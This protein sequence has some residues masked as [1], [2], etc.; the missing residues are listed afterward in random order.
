M[1]RFLAT[2]CLLFITAAC[3]Y[4]Q[5]VLRGTVR[6]ELTG[7]PM[8]GVT[9]FE[10]GTSNGTITDNEGQYELR[11][12]DAQ[13]T[14]V[15][16]FVGY[17]TVEQAGGGDL[18]LKEDVLMLDEVVVTAL[19]ITSDKKALGYSVQKVGGDAL[20]S[21]GE[22][23]VINGLNAKVAGVQVISSSGTPGASSFIRIRGSSSLTGNN[24]P[25]IVVDGI[26]MDNSQNKGG[27]PDDEDNTLLEGVGQSNRAIDINP[28]DIQEVTVL[29]GPAAAALYGIQAA[30]GAILI[31][32]KKGSTSTG[33]GVNVSFNTSM[34]WDMVNKLPARQDQYAQGITGTYAG[35]ET[36][37]PYSWGP[38]IDTLRWDN[39]P[40]P[41]DIYEYDL[42]GRIVGQ[43]DPSGVEQVTPYDPYDFFQTGMTTD[44]SLALSGGN[45]T[46]TY[47]FS[48]GN[49]HQTGVV[50]LSTFN[51]TTAKLA[52]ESQLSP[53]LRTAASVGYTNSGGRRVQQ[54]SN[55]SGLMLGLL[56]TPPT[57]DNSNGVTDPSDE[58]AYI[59]ADGSQR[60][61]RGGGGYDN[62]YWTINKNPFNDEV[63]RVYGF[64][65]VT[66]DVTN[67]LNIFYRLGSDAYS[68]HR[69]QVFAINSR[70]APAGRIYLEKH[71]YR[72]I[73]SDLWV[74]AS[75]TFS[76]KF[77]GSL[78]VGNNLFSKSY[79]KLYTQGDGFTFADFN[80]ISNAQSV[81]S[82][83][84][85]EAK[86]TAAAFFEAKAAFDDWIFL[87]VTGRNEWSSTLPTENNSFFYPAASLGL[88]FTEPLN[89][90]ENK[91][92]PFGKLRLSYASVGNDADPYSLAKYYNSAVVGDGWTSGVVFPFNG[93]SGFSANDILGSANLKP[94]R[95]NTIEI[96]TDLRFLQNRIGLDF[97]VYRSMSI[98]QIMN[99]PVAASSGYQEL[100][101]N[102]GTISN[103]GIE[104]VLNAT[105]I[106]KE[107]FR[108]DITVNFTKNISMV[109]ELAEGIETV[110]LGGFEGSSIRNVAGQPYGQFYGGSF[111]RDDAG[112]LVIESDTS[113]FFYGFPIESG[114]EEVLGNPNPDF[115]AGLTNTISL[116]GFMLNI[117]FDFRYGGEIWNGTQG[118][119]TFFGTS[120]N[121]EDRGS[122][123]VFE[124]VKGT[125]DADGNL[126]LQDES[127]SAGT[128]Q[129]DAEVT[130]TEDW[131]LTNGGGFGFVAEHFV[132][133]ISWV[134]LR[135][136]S[137]GYTFPSKIFE[138]TPI[139]S[140]NLGVSGRNLL[141]MTPYEGVDPETN[142][143]GS[144]NAQGLDYFNMPN[145]RSISARLGITF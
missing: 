124:G 137:L 45:A 38:S 47:R 27:N 25:L 32:T 143:M 111:L 115:L 46:S 85:T 26:P 13:A 109:E 108:W 9:V 144:M 22:S 97:T 123:T 48:I 42:H 90:S 138:R 141:L 51:R 86:K 41:N 36:G 58:S 52:G 73:N 69:Q 39:N 130:L 5:E 80:H 68:D 49:T 82:R 66:Y 20:V 77:S 59:L 4:A 21:S 35:P 19:G 76:E 128:F 50:P 118:A 23:N 56:R 122:T 116:K 129:N 64:A 62:P 54:G 87:D 40:D 110:F 106:K 55:T 3:V 103:K 24:Q 65:S 107:N 134:R 119:M 1:K 53:R 10:K 102:A 37:L 18:S 113:S 101:T 145:T 83:D 112:N 17:A 95:N 126:I 33:K 94:T 114:I 70:T 31:T 89:M 75:R 14:L 88:V 91:I 120:E 142:L 133:D 99:V 63:N 104:I 12:K 98:N 131:Y 92:L 135:E 74:T 30:N 7:E 16:R 61:Y 67:W 79:N 78:L 84:Y 127:G 136:V 60:N 71:N 72:H 8:P 125:R 44:N 57:F 93:V 28:N 132:Q 15:F 100:I 105:P 140:L 121:T 34:S 139:S 29:K 6:E 2:A 81:F 117:L 96:G 11:V 43:S